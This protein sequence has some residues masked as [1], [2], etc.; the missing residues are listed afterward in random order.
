MAEEH[1]AAFDWIKAFFPN[2]IY[3]C[4]D[5]GC[6][7]GTFLENIEDCGEKIGI[8]YSKPYNEI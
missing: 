4:L 3:R 5:F 6:G 2:G 1:E 8:D 7:T